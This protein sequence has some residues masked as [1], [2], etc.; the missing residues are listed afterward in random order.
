M[1][2]KS[3]D[4]RDSISELMGNIGTIGVFMLGEIRVLLKKSWGSSRQEFWSAVDQAATN[5]KRSGKLAASDIETASTKIKEAWETLDQE[6]N[7]D[8]DSFIA[9]LKQRLKLLGYVSKDVFS[10]CVK[11]TW[12]LLDKQWTAFGRIGEQSLKQ[13]Q[14]QSGEI[15]KTVKEGLDS[16]LSNVQKTGKKLDKAFDAA[17]NEIK[18]KD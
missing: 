18:K 11:Q 17:W 7:L 4:V 3:P 14:G 6:R 8:W 1:D 15:A 16:L 13:V 9:D 10:L 5:L 2:K 12:E